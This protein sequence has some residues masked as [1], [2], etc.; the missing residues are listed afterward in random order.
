M[1]EMSKVTGIVS[2]LFDRVQENKLV[3]ILMAF[4]IG[5]DIG[6]LICH[7]RSMYTLITVGAISTLEI[8]CIVIGILFFL[9]FNSIL[10]YFFRMLWLLGIIKTGLTNNIEIDKTGFTIK[11][12]LLY[13]IKY[14]N[15]IVERQYIFFVK[16]L[17]NEKI[18]KNLVFTFLILLGIDSCYEGSLIRLV[19]NHNFLIVLLFIFIF[20][21]IIYVSTVDRNENATSGIS[22]K[23]NAGLEINE[24]DNLF[25]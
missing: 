23:M 24:G 6:L 5:S 9:F 1:L 14:N 8:S 11:E 12:L 2:G 13:S 20:Y 18:S 15:S 25:E 16:K 21:C 3:F 4:I 10:S 22:K 17:E 19:W 7:Q